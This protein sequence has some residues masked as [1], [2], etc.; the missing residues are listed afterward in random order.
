[1]LSVKQILKKMHSN[2]I[3]KYYEKKINKINRQTIVYHG[4]IKG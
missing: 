3:L 2:N 1:M 4:K